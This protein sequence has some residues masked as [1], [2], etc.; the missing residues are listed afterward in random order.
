M[1]IK[2]AGKKAGE[3][4]RKSTPGLAAKAKKKIETRGKKVDSAMDRMLA[5]K[6]PQKKKK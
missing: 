5:G 4:A 6:S 3:K 2:K 1:A